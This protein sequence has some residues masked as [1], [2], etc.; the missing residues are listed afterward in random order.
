MSQMSNEIMNLHVVAM[1]RKCYLLEVAAHASQAHINS[2]IDS[3]SH[4]ILTHYRG[5]NY[6]G[7]FTLA[8]LSSISCAHCK[9]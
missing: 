3:S 2:S 7:P 4:Y 5:D 1:Q 8:C 6:N 9:D